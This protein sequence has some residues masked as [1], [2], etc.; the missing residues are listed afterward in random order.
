MK[1]AVVIGGGFFGMFIAEHLAL[2][3]NKVFIVEKEA[4]FMTRASYANQARVHNGYHYPRSILTASRSQV[5]FP[6]FVNEFRSCIDDTFEKYYMIAKV[7]GKVTAK[8]FEQFCNRIGAPCE[9]APSRITRLT[10]PDLIEAVYLTTE[11]AFDAVKLREA[12][13]ERLDRAGVV[14]ITDTLVDNVYAARDK[15]LMV[16]VVRNDGSRG[17]LEGMDNVFNCTYSMINFINRKSGISLVPLKHEL[18]EI[19]LV[20]MPSPLRDCGVTV[21]CGP[22][23]SFLPF[24]SKHCHSFTHVRYTPHYS[25]VDGDAAS[26]IDAHRH[27]RDTVRPSAWNTMW[28]DAKRYIP[29]LEQ[30]RYLD[31]IWEVKTILPRS[32]SDDSRPI[33]F[34]ANYGIEGFHCVMGGKIDNAY[35]AVKEIDRLALLRQVP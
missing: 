25:W 11:Y 19:C 5:A 3:G 1:A 13:K 28:R 4:D 18:T 31:S 16:S 10:N 8:Q 14:A 21:M 30:V 2:N 32:E 20:E 33:L 22:F 29:L 15:R 24:P 17:E 6:R 7:L 9:P 26:Y 23:F 35:D 34:K 27:C 12:M